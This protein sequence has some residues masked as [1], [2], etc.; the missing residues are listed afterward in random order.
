MA[1]VQVSSESWGFVVDR[2]GRPVEG[3]LCAI[4]TTVYTDEDGSGTID[5]ADF[6]TDSEG[7]LPGWVPPGRY[8]FTETDSDTRTVIAGGGYQTVMDEA[9]VMAKRDTLRFEGAAVSVQDDA[10]ND[11]TR[12][13]VTGSPGATGPAGETFGVDVWDQQATPESVTDWGPTINT[14]I[15]AGHK[16]LLFRNESFPFSTTI[17]TAD[18]VTFQGQAGFL[19]G[20]TLGQTSPCNLLWKGGASSGN[21]IDGGTNYGFTMRDMAVYWDSAAYDGDLIDPGAAFPVFERCDFG[22]IPRLASDLPGA[23]TTNC[24][25]IFYLDLCVQPKFVDCQFQDAE[26]LIYGYDFNPSPGGGTDALFDTCLFQG[27]CTHHVTNPTQ[28]WTFKDC[29]F[30]YVGQVADSFFCD[31]VAGS[32]DDYQVQ[33]SIKGCWFWDFDE[34]GTGVTDKCIINQNAFCRWFINTMDNKVLSGGTN[35]FWRLNGP[36]SLQSFGDYFSGQL[37]DSSDYYIDLGD[38]TTALKRHVTIVGPS[39]FSGSSP[40]YNPVANLTAHRQVNLIGTSRDGDSLEVTTVAGHERNGYVTGNST[41]LPTVAKAAGQYAGGAVEVYGN[42]RNGVI[43]VTVPSAT[44]TVAGDLVEVTFNKALVRE[45]FTT[46]LGAGFRV[47]TVQLTPADG[48]NSSN[49]STAA[50]ALVSAKVSS[51]DY[52]KFTVKTVNAIAG[53]VVVAWFY[54]VGM[55]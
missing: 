18:G 40:P 22:M 13:I 10:G 30:E 36:G 47:P 1:L 32:P 43:V 34:R 25:S 49:G 20:D 51:S 21:A 54:R 55:I 27:L 35:K 41:A 17:A 4:D 5:P 24:H 42:D 7:L 50:S 31:L 26:N 19:W 9:T 52:T 37:A 14:L 11:R 23:I 2:R 3:A 33:L 39:W 29:V 45:P 53:A 48:V 46:G 12:V 38:A 15:S 8:T 6:V 16:L 28:S 44:S